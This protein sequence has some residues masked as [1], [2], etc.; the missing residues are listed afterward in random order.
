LDARAINFFQNQIQVEQKVYYR[1][2][3]AEDEAK[4]GGSVM[5]GLPMVAFQ[6]K[7]NGDSIE[8]TMDEVFGFPKEESYGGG[9]GAKGVLSIRAGAYSV[10]DAHYFTTGELYRFYLAL[11]ECYD[12]LDGEAVLE[13][14]DRELTLKCVFNKNGHVYVSGEFQAKPA[15]ANI[16]IFEFRTDQTQIKSTLSALKAVYKEFGGQHGLTNLIEK[17]MY[18]PFSNR[19]KNKFPLN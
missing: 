12:L 15:V 13:N 14:V 16:L 7:G 19:N 3:Y 6:I 4:A 11:K 1:W 10:T 8:L 18:P 17:S 5:R 2:R 9:Y